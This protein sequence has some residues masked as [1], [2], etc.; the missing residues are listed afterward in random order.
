MKPTRYLNQKN[1]LFI[2]VILLAMAAACGLTP[3]T[4]AQSIYTWN[5]PSGSSGN[6]SLPA[7]WALPT[8]G[9]N[10]PLANDFVV[11]TNTGASTSSNTVNNIVDAGFAGTVADLTY[12]S[13][14]QSPYIYNVTQIPAGTLTVTNRL[15]VGGLNEPGNTVSPWTTYA[16]INGAGTL[17]FT[18]TNFAVQNFSSAS[19]TFLTTCFFDLSGLT[20]FVMNSPGGTISIADTVLPQT[21]GTLN[22]RA[23][24]NLALANG[25]NSIT[26]ATINLATCNAPQ[27]GAGSSLNFGG[28]TNIVNANTFNIANQK[29]SATVSFYGPNGGLRIRGTNGSD[30]SR[31]TITVG[32]RSVGGGTGVTTGQMLLNGHPVNI[33]ANT[34][35]VG[36]V[37]VTPGPSGAAGEFG[38]GTLQFDTGV[39]DATN[40]VMAFNEAPNAAGGLSGSTSVLT[41]GGGATLNVGTGGISLI[42]QTASNV[43]SSTLTI[44][45]GTVNCNG[46]ITAA[47]NAAAG[48]GG[49][50]ET[51]IIQ[52]IGG[53]T[54]TLGS[55][56]FAGTTNAPISQII[57]DVNSKLQ[58]VAPPSG[59]PAVVV[60][61]LAWPANDSALTLVISNLPATASAGATIPLIQFASM[62][63]GTFTSPV[64]VLPPGVTGSLSLS[65]NMIVANITS[66]IYPTIAP[67]PLNNITLCTNT[68]L[69]AVAS[70]TSTTITNVT[71]I[72]TTT[73]LGGITSTTVTNTLGS[74]SLTVNGLN[75]GT[76]QI[77]YTL[78]ANTVYQSVTV[79]IADGSGRTASLPTVNFD[80]LVPSLV[81]EASDFNF[82][83]NSVD[84][85]FIDTPANGGFALYTNQVGTEGIDE[86]KIARTAPKSYYRPTDAVIVQNANPGLGTPASRTEQKFVTAAA[87]G[88]LVNVE[89]EI[90]FNSPGDWLNYTRTYGA[91]GSAPS[92]TYNIWAYLATSGSGIQSSLSQVTSN[93]GQGGQTTNFLGN[94]GSASFSDNGFNNFVYV[95]LQD[96]FGNRATVT[97][98]SGQQTFKSVIVG[99]PNVAF[100]MLVPVAPIF[101]PVLLQVYPNGNTPFQPTNE[102]T[103]VVGPA[104]GSAVLTN[105]ISLVLNGVNV[106]SGLTFSLVNGNWV[107]TYAIL[108]N[109]V[110][111]AVINVT[112]LSGLSTTF[113]NSF[114]TFNVNNYTWEAVDYDFST[115]TG[116]GLGTDGTVGDGWNAGLFIDNPVPT[117]DTNGVNG[118]L[119]EPNSYFLYPTA[120][121]IF[122]DGL[123]AKAHQGVDVNYTNAPGIQH[124]YRADIVGSEITSDFLRPKFIAAQTQFGDPA[125]CTFDLG[126]FNSGFWVNYTR[127]YPT[128]TYNVWARL[129]GG[130]GAFSG[131]TLSMVTSGVG[132]SNQTTQVLGSFADPNAA[133]WQTWHWIPLLDSQGNKV[134]VTLGGKATLR[135]T[136]GN[137]LNAE[138]LMLA[139]A[140]LL[141]FPATAQVVGANIQI[142]FPTL[143]GH[144]YKL[145]NAPTLTGTWTQVGGTVPGDGTVHMIPQPVSGVQG[146][147]QVRAQ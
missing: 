23:N 36:E 50:T 28:G 75:T 2:T 26:V 78:V 107:A 60:N 89:Q 33:L 99:N 84:G 113:S 131:T 48:R 15:L 90:G 35:V 80:T 41:V 13:I 92:G 105:D 132:T 121:T 146:Y 136:S 66:T 62:T 18:G 112:N 130:A 4:E 109:N 69:K 3:V 47:T 96:Q 138:C 127:T 17:R 103:F 25:S 108:S 68:A 37:S 32:N 95:P 129:A 87:N 86:H 106:S 122:N 139:T 93:P 73:T 58:F 52:F 14:T 51:N 140:P 120:Y 54:L 22:V 100:Y 77:S 79:Q 19:S 117:G 49:S 115:N 16:F 135:L 116:S 63:G 110:Y 40:L 27:A 143:S 31:S 10:G 85:Q 81:I 64:L 70:S 20:N 65:G 67:I 137:N 42:N 128:N 104:Q 97:F 5:I 44:S 123:G 134:A 147:Y 124:N 29:N 94:F 21:S 102:F 101:T 57:L 45:N 133:G 142:S 53:G 7:N 8:T 111:T 55:S 144:S 83:S 145:Y 12:N 43:C 61:T 11:F 34:L 125:I 9:P 74:P 6:W 88:D 114:D 82:T 126:W 91:S 39:I 118:Q 119:L 98:A 76:A 72:A 24:G 71:V 56:C 38:N 46:N 1:T 30:T 59:Q 141:P